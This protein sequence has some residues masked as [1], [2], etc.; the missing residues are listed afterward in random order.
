MR[1]WFTTEPL[2]VRFL[3]DDEYREQAEA[4]TAS[5]LE[6]LRRACCRPDFPSWLA[7]SRLQAPK[8]FADFVLGASHLSPEEVSTHETQYGLGGAFLEEQ[9]FSL[10]TDSLPAS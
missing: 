1:S 9:L 7:V 10:H 3:T 2:V 4:S 6:E 5:A 8:K